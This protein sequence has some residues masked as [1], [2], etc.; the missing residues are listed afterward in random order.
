[1]G[2]DDSEMRRSKFRQEV[3]SRFG[4]LPN[5]F[6]SAQAAPGVI[7][8]LWTFAKSG[9]LDNPLPSVFK[10]RLFVHLSRYCDMRYCIVRHVG[11]L[12]GYGRPAGDAGV[13]PESLDQAIEL[14]R[15]PLPNS[16]ELI[17]ILQRMSA[18]NK[19]SPMP[20]SGTQAEAD[21]FDALTF[22]FVE[23][24]YSGRARDA[25]RAVVGDTAFEL[26]TAYLAFIRTA[27][28]WTET[29][30]EIPYEPDMLAL[31]EE[32]SDLATLMLDS[33]DAERVKIKRELVVGGEARPSE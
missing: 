11:F 7:E 10:E 16:T 2:N 20:D 27:H 12:V 33:S 32:R 28:F 21:L 8:G 30:P 24:T 3:A 26:L 25:V 19:P 9:Y 13:R 5:F 23:P 6:C 15:R 22:I 31:M 1:M 14:L 18:F 4:V 29:H 17:S